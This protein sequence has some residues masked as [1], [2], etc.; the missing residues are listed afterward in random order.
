[1]KPIKTGL[2]SF[3]MSGSVFHAPLIAEH[4]SFELTAV[5]ERSQNRASATYPH[6]QIVRTF[7]ELLTVAD[8]ELIVVNTPDITH[9][10]YCKLALEAGKHVVVEKPFVFTVEEGHTLV[11]IA[12]ANH[13]ML[14][15]FQNRRW[16]G[17]FLTLKKVVESGKLG[18]LVEI[19]SG[20]QRYRNVPIQGTWKETAYRFVGTTYNLG[21]HL[22]DQMVELL[23]MPEGVF[24][25][26]KTLRDRGQVDDYFHILLI[27]P[28]VQVS[29][30]A[31]YLMREETPRFIAHGSLGSFVKYGFDPQ[32]A[33]L[34]SGMPPFDPQFGLDPLE[35]R[36]ILHTETDGEVV[37]KPIETERGNYPAYYDQVA[38]CIRNGAQTPVSASDNLK[39]I[40]LLEAAF[41]SSKEGRIIPVQ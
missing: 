25:Q 6:T 29:L 34:R 7:E 17:D 20:F 11:E 5:C 38:D 12:K 8:I 16:D 40:G 18:R 33:M 4:P 27:Y 9:F 15:V 36:G 21:S 32:E 41:Q 35:K 13:R 26:I 3:G 19:R 23:G 2:A 39:M 22:V 14:S 31:G 37:R 1:M 28:D 10:D 30:T 24:A